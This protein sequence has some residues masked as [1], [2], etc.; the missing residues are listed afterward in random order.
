MLLVLVVAGRVAGGLEVFFKA[1]FL[2]CWGGLGREGGGRETGVGVGA[3]VGLGFTGSFC[4]GEG[5][6]GGKGEGR[7]VVRE[8]RKG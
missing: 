1:I 8:R 4:W 5:G 6:K 2:G 7:G 3:G